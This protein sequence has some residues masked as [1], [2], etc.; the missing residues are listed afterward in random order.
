MS[1][2]N[3]SNPLLCDFSFVYLFFRRLFSFFWHG[4]S[5]SVRPFQDE[6]RG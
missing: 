2:G 1:C 5:P 6:M 4:V 3:Y